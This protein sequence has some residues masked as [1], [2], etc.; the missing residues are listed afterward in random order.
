MHGAARRKMIVAFILML[1]A[2]IF[3]TVPAPD[4]DVAELLARNVEHF[5]FSVSR[6]ELGTVSGAEPILI[7][8]GSPDSGRHS[9]QDG[10]LR[11][12]CR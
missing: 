4:A 11:C 6:S 7:I 2:I 3:C 1:Q 9:Y 12:R 8:I 10:L 5:P